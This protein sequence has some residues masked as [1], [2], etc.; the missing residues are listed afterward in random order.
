[1]FDEQDAPGRRS[2][3]DRA[4]ATRSPAA[5]SRLNTAIGAFRPLLRDLMPVAAQ[6]GRRRRRSSSASSAALE[7]AA[8][9]VAPVAET[10]AELFVNLDTTFTA[11]ARSRA[12]SSRTRSP[13]ARRRWTRR[14][15]DLPVQRPFLRQHAAL[16]HELRARRRAR[17]AP[18]RPTWPT[19]SRSARRRCA[20][21]VALNQRLEPTLRRAAG[22]SPRTRWSPLGVKRLTDT[23][24]I[25]QPDARVPHAA[26]TVCNYVDAVVPQR[27]RLLSEG[28]KNGTWQRFIIVADA[29]GP[30]QRGRPVQRRRPT[31]RAPTTTCTPTRTRTRRRRASPRSARPAT[32]PTCRARP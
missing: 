6:P 3:P 30:E 32:R 2:Q 11:L 28:D 17:C 29:A 4:S 15:R 24:T 5:A 8:A 31:A 21:S 18:P 1:M 7:R 9:I 25:A 20:R 23:S 10:Q 14:S 13:R 12:R 19:R 26:Q 16:F 22:A 27:R